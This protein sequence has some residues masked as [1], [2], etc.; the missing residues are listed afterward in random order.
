MQCIVVLVRNVLQVASGR[1]VA[2]S[3]KIVL[4]D[5]SAGHEHQAAGNRIQRRAEVHYTY[6]SRAT[7]SEWLNAVT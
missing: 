5:R 4:A 1:A 7:S 3:W 2:A 6:F